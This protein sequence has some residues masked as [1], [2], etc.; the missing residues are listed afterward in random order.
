MTQ[1]INIE[2]CDTAVQ[3]FVETLDTTAVIILCKHGKPC[4]VVGT[5]DEFEWEVLSL[6][7]NPAFLEYLEHARQ[8]GKREGTI[9]I[10]E[11]Q[12]RLELSSDTNGDAVTQTHTQEV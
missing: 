10:E 5:I 6:S 1:T 4:Y 3:E 12:R 11:I 9:P 2:E 7:H 8:R